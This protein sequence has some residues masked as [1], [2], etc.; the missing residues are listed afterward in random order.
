VIN[1]IH[2][3]GSAAYR[4]AKTD[5]GR[6]TRSCLHPFSPTGHLTGSANGSGRSKTTSTDRSPHG[7]AAPPLPDSSQ[8]TFT[9]LLVLLQGNPR[10][11]AIVC[12]I[13]DDDELNQT[14]L[15]TLSRTRRDLFHPHVRPPMADLSQTLQRTEPHRACLLGIFIIEHGHSRQTNIVGMYEPQRHRIAF[16]IPFSMVEWN[17]VPKGTEVRKRSLMPHRTRIRKSKPA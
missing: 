8:H 9:T 7:R 3:E 2:T 15:S 12:K 14:F 5:A 4:L 10:I 6:S 1:S 11:E 13:C 16:R 17:R